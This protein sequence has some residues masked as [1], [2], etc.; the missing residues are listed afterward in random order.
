MCLYGAYIGLSVILKLMRI[1]DLSNARFR[2]LGTGE[3]YPAT[4]TAIFFYF[5]THYDMLTFLTIF[6]SI[7]GFCVIFFA[8]YNVMI[9]R[10]G[11]TSYE[12]SKIAS[13][14][15]Y[16][17]VQFEQGK[18]VVMDRSRPLEER[19]AAERKLDVIN[20]SVDVINRV[21]RPD[22]WKNIRAMLSEQPQPTN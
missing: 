4:P 2:N 3:E 6:C 9:V 16:N 21:Y 10:D 1:H 12:K 15:G 18:A 17:Y 13:V 19:Q 14:M 8:A 22:F 20:Q 11:V 5:F 7:M